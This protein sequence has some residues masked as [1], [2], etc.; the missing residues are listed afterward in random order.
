LKRLA[1]NLQTYQ[2]FKTMDTDSKIDETTFAFFGISH[3][4]TFKAKFQNHEL[5]FD[6][7]LTKL[8]IILK[9]PSTKN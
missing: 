8:C 3:F 6:V 4:K 5:S 7:L 9:L 2:N 1:D